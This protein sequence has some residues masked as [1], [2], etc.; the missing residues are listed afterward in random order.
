MPQVAVAALI[1]AGGA[2]ASAAIGGTLA[3]LTISTVVGA[4]LVSA[5]ATALQLS[6]APSTTTSPSLQLRI[7]TP[8]G[9]FAY[10]RCRKSGAATYGE[11]GGP[12][13]NSVW[14]VLPI[15]CHEIDAVEEIYDGENLLWDGSLTPDYSGKTEVHIRLGTESQTAVSNLINDVPALDS[16]FRG[17]THA[18]IAIRL[19]GF[20]KRWSNRV[21]AIWA[22]VRGAKVFDPR[23]STTAWTANWALCVAHYLEHS[24]GGN[25]SNVNSSSLIAA[26]NISDEEVL[27][28][29]AL[30]G[31]EKWWSGSSG[32]FR[33]HRRY[34]I[35]GEFPTSSTPKQNLT[36]MMLYGVGD[37]F[38][39]GGEYHIS[40]GAYSA[41]V[42]SFD[43]DDFVF[44]APLISSPVKIEDQIDGVRA[45]YANT[46]AF[47][48]SDDAPDIS[49]VTGTA[50]RF[51]DL[52]L[53]KEI[54]PE[55][56][57]R[58]MAMFGR[59]TFR[60]LAMS[61]F[62]PI[63]AMAVEVGDTVS[64]DL[65]EVG[66]SADFKVEK[67][68]LRISP[69]GSYVSFDLLEDRAEFWSWD[70]DDAGAVVASSKSTLPS[71][72]TVQP[73]TNL[74]LT[75]IS[76]VGGSLDFV[77]DLQVA[78]TESTSA[79]IQTYEVSWRTYTNALPDPLQSALVSTPLFAIK[80]LVTGAKVDVYVTA[81][82]ILGVE[83][84]Q[85]SVLDYTFV[86]RASLVSTLEINQDIF[87]SN[88]FPI[89]ALP[90][91]EGSQYSKVVF[92]IEGS[93]RSVIGFY[94]TNLYYGASVLHTIP[95]DVVYVPP[96]AAN[97]RHR[98]TF[99]AEPLF[100]V[101]PL[102]AVK[103]NIVTSDNSL[104]MNGTTDVINLIRISV[105]Q[106]RR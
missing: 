61:V 76:P 13:G 98:L 33:T 74:T 21:P 57:Q 43:K 11:K 56:A 36:Q 90:Q 18:Y 23:N 89:L 6:T 49:Y 88:Q 48:V 62:L 99:T 60:R 94:M 46:S 2:V 97:V 58:V 47:Y 7:P 70:K 75:E 41:P 66:V 26:A 101:G 65:P 86:G 77:T 59:K 105:V 73:P 27:D 45:T 16:E 10:G 95:P 96:Y 72:S 78:W 52:D 40:A 53:S 103:L 35:N 29:G 50:Q 87:S 42:A 63:S 102:S 67:K 34:E 22:Q 93:L 39:S 8:I 54:H 100:K 83:S 51:L 91:V 84:S 68:G 81:I 82:N 55:R 79:Y 17:R 31:E 14:L 69:E 80:G 104:T 9:G 20:A 64:I 106:Y 5:S 38:E 28:N 4:A 30:V 37:L 85:V 25:K 71:V 19:V 24:R 12:N 1:G 32:G 3:S 92:E 15:A 44:Q